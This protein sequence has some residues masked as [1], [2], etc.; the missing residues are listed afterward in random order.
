MR[1]TPLTI[2]L[3]DSP[4]GKAT[5]GPVLN[6]TR[7]QREQMFDS[8]VAVYCKTASFLLVGD[9][10]VSV[11]SG[12]GFM[13][14]EIGGVEAASGDLINGNPFGE[15]TPLTTGRRNGD[16]ARRRD[17]RERAPVA[18]P[19]GGAAAVA[20]AT[21]LGP[22]AAICESVHPTRHPLCS[23]GLGVPVGIAGV[24]AT[25]GIAY[26]DWRRQR[27]HLRPSPAL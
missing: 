6:L 17:V 24:L 14:A 11:I 5:V 3:K 1:V 12:T 7:E 13:T 23:H 15:F 2:T 19:A 4:V 22:L 27:R 21:D 10:T 26:L 25:S 9:I 8:I 20:K 18:G 16:R